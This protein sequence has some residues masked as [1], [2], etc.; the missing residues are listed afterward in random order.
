MSLNVHPTKKKKKME[1]KEYYSILY[2]ALVYRI[3]VIYFYFMFTMTHLDSW[4]VLI[5]YVK[6]RNWLLLTLSSYQFLLP[7][8]HCSHG[9]LTLP[10]CWAPSFSPQYLDRCSPA[11]FLSLLGMT[12][13]GESSLITPNMTSWSPHTSVSSTLCISHYLVLGFSFSVGSLR[14]QTGSCPLW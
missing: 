3:L 2:N 6:K 8:P 1:R 12:S 4:I 7:C 11:K 5:V 9:W 13:S 14:S 10:V